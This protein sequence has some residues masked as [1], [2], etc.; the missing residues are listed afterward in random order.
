MHELEKLREIVLADPELQA[1]LLAIREEELFAETASQ[2]AQGHGIDLTPADILGALQD[3]RRS[4]H[5]R[6]VR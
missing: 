1:R 6:T 2:V 3:A 5:E 4:W